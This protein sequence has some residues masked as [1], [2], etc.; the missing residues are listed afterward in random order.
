VTFE[1]PVTPGQTVMI[2]LRPVEESENPVF[3][4]WRHG[5]PWR[6]IPR[7]SALDDFTSETTTIQATGSRLDFTL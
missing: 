4:Y 2:G 7:C 3:I 6:E 1:P 5:F